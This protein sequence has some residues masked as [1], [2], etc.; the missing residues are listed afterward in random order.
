MRGDLPPSS[1]ETGT[2]RSLASRITMRPTSV[3]PAAAVGRRGR[4]GGLV[5]EQEG[6]A[7]E[8]GA[9]LCQTPSLPSQ[10]LPPTHPRTHP[11]VNASLS[12][13]GWRQMAA[14]A[15]GP[16]PGSTLTTPSGKPAS[17]HRLQGKVW[18]DG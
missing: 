8:H 3:E 10:S 18:V 5:G 14:P 2:M 15:V 4:V 11:P 7:G 9:V 13:S 12:T 17:W 6:S 16:K 1:R